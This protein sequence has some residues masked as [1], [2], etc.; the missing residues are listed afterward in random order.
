MSLEASALGPPDHW[1]YAFPAP[2]SPAVLAAGVKQSGS[3]VAAACDSERYRST[4]SQSGW[5]ALPPVAVTV[6]SNGLCLQFLSTQTWLSGLAI[7]VPLFRASGFSFLGSSLSEKIRMVL[8]RRR[9]F[10]PR[11][12]RSPGMRLSLPL[13]RPRPS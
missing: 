5:G 10:F 13:Y 1:F 7:A 11:L 8:V 2:T 6:V 12:F 3:S 9:L 4:P